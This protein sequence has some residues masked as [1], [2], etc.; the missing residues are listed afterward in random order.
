MPTASLGFRPLVS[1]FAF[2]AA[3]CTGS[4]ARA[5]DAVPRPAVAVKLGADGRLAYDADDAG[6]RVIDFSHAGYAGG[7]EAIPSVP[8]KLVVAPAPD[9]QRDRERIQAALDLVAAM[10]AGPDGF[11]GAVLLT[12]G[13]FLI[14]ES[15]QLN[16]SG[17]VLRGSGAGENG[18]VL[19]ATGTSRRTLIEIGGRGER[20]ETAGSRRSVTDAYVPVG[21]TKL[22]V[23][24]TAGLAVGDR[25]IKAVAHTL[26]DHCAGNMVARIG[27]EEFVVLFPGLLPEAAAE[28]LDIA[29]EILGSR[30]FKL[31][32]TDQPLGK[33][34]FSGGVALGHHPDG[35][36]ALQRADAL[37]YAAKNGGRNQVHWEVA[38]AQAA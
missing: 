36:P 31:R 2:V 30:Y 18:T 32:E 16:A 12:T 6:N 11:R 4:A 27:G 14:D 38:Q 10:P 25:V 23:E 17:V 13:S 28:I 1:L 22:T 24:N 34:T 9:G 5:A 7:G 19:R 15:L 8:A 37:L 26:R 33:V 20:T 21:A 3:C 29:R 35:A